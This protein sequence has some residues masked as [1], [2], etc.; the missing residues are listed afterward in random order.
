MTGRGYYWVQ[1]EREAV[2]YGFP[3]TTVARSTVKLPDTFG[4]ER[5]SKRP[6]TKHSITRRNFST[7]AW[8]R[9]QQSDTVAGHSWAHNR[10][11]SQFRNCSLP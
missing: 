5:R 11:G 6:R 9:S 8:A 2:I 3:I 7:T 10:N 1:R 4:P